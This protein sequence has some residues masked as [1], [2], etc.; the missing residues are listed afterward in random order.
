MLLRIDSGRTIELTPEE[1]E[2][3]VNALWLVA[4]TTRGAVVA[5]GK[6]E[7]RLR[8]S[9]A[10]AIELSATESYALDLALEE[11]ADTAPSPSRLRARI[12]S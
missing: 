2:L 12:A 1:A 8:D 5:I 6:I 3:L 11:G 10:S 7:Y 4:A 9:S